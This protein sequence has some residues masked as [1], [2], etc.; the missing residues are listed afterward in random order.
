MFRLLSFLIGYAFGCIQS[1]FITGK[2]VKG[3][4]IRDHGSK[5]SG[6]TNA[7]RVMGFKI[8]VWVFIADMAKAVLAFLVASWLFDGSGSFLNPDAANGLLP[9]VWAG[10]GVVLGHCFP[11]FMKFRGGKGIS[12]TVGL[13]FMLD[14]RA[15]VII[16]II[17][18][19]LILIFRYISL[20][21]LVITLLT[22][23]FMAIFAYGWE[24]MIVTI[25]LAAIAWFMHRENIKLLLKGEERK[26]SFRKKET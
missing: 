19:I 11:V 8:G 7:N 1:A 24:V 21:S 16:Y 10:L 4:D 15:A 12:C 2:L 13:V 23:I 14:W 9:G 25:V 5:N 17:A 20:A 22:P 26:F 18:I 6:F 3:I